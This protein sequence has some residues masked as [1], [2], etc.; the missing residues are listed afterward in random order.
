MVG[1]VGKKAKGL[2]ARTEYGRE[3][4]DVRQVGSSEG[5]VVGNEKIPGAQVGEAFDQPAGAYPHRP[6]V[7]GDVRGVGD[8]AAGG[9][10]I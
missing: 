3:Y 5:R 1:P 4:R 9:V 8:Q 6:E 2:V 10:V 7:N